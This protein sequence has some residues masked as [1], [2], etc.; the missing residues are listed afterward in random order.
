VHGFLGSKL[1]DVKTGKVAWGTMANVL[2]GR[3]NE[4]LSLPLGPGD[5][6]TALE[7]YEIYD[8]LWGVEYYRKILRI[9]QDSGG[10]RLGDI[11]NPKP[12]DTAF[13]FIYDWR[14]DNVDSARRLAA[15]LERLRERLGDPST[16]FDLLTHSQGGLIARYFVRYGGKDVLDSDRVPVPTLAGAPLVDKVVMLGTP[17][18]GCLEAMKILH[19]GIRKFFRPMPTAVVF[20]M[21]SLYQMLPPPGS[22]VFASL[23]GHPVDLDLYDADTWVREGW[24]VFAKETQS[25]LSRKLG[26]KKATE[27]LEER[28]RAYRRF[29][30]DSLR[31]SA[32]FH[33]ALSAPV[34]GGDPVAYYAFGSD[35]ISTLRKAIVVERAGRREYHFDNRDF[36]SERFGERTAAILYGPGDGTVPMQSL[37]DLPETGPGSAAAAS[38]ASVN[39]RSAFFVCESH[40]LLPNDPTFQNNLFYLLLWGARQAPEKA[41]PPPPRAS[42]GS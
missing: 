34:P 18:R 1:R 8:S 6:S 25:R 39:F 37:L 15:T 42:V 40:G 24:S 26:K 17:N 13:V 41:L 38:T 4:A 23:D 20:T 35:C 11:E 3:V 31:R 33:R 27:T 19:H 29:L 21:P 9:L 32:R 22:Q 12:G 30:E 28:N 10:Y 2:S 5:P 14:Q 16:R 36:R 7:A